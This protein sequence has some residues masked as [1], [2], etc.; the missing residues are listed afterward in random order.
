MGLIPYE[1]ETVIRMG[2]DTDLA[3]VWTCQPAVARRL[4]KRG[5]VPKEIR[6]Q[7]GREVAWRFLLPSAWVKLGPPRMGRPLSDGERARAAERLRA[8]RVAPKRPEFS[9][10]AQRMAVA[11]AG[12][13][14][15]KGESLGGR[16]R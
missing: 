13:E 10:G 14:P 15:R 4:Q 8:A 2:D 6:R 1:R 12:S 3:S 16:R 5:A 9:P 7:D 11:P